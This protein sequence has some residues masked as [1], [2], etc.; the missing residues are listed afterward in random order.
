MRDI[1]NDN[2]AS[3]PEQAKSPSFPALTPTALAALRAQIDMTHM[4]PSYMHV[5]ESLW[6]DMVAEGLD[7]CVPSKCTIVVGGSFSTDNAPDV[8][9]DCFNH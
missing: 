6:N 8:F 4:R 3:V 2:P 9:H 7:K 5:S 1:N